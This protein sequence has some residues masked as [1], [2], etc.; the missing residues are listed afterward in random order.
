MQAGQRNFG[1]DIVRSIAIISVLICH[2][3]FLSDNKDLNAFL[4]IKIFSLL[5][6]FSGVNLFFVLS[7]YLIGK[8]IITLFSKELSISNIKTFYIRR[9]FRTL[10]LYYLSLLIY[11]LLRYDINVFSSFFLKFIFFLQTFDKNFY[12][13]FFFPV[14]WSLAV[15]EWF[16]LLLP[17]ILFVFFKKNL[18]QTN[19]YI[20]II[21]LITLITFVK[22]GYTL[23]S[24]QNLDLGT[25]SFLPFRFDSLLTGVVFASLKIN[26]QDIFE[27]FLNKK[28]IIICFILFF[29]SYNIINFY[30]QSKI[31]LIFQNIIFPVIIN[32][33]GAIFIIFFENNK[34]INTKLKKISL[35]RHFFEKTSLYSYSMY[36]FHLILYAFYRAVFSNPDELFMP[37][38]ICLGTIYLFSA[39]IYRY[40]EKPIMDMRERF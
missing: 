2:W 10:P 3:Y 31:F 27:K 37:I 35:I 12:S 32:F 25:Q 7:G 16:Y 33:V 9:W 20:K 24:N 30:A 19:L 29:I 28:T 34:F 4:N 13:I 22:I 1:L 23:L 11:L 14:S 40:Y 18:K 5:S 6:W 36:L 17:L 8:I 15:E 39:L 21:A 26:N 38:L